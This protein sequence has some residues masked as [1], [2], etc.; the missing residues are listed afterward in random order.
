LRIGLNLLHA[1]PAIGGAWNYIASVL[2][3]L[4]RLDTRNQYIAYCNPASKAL[5]AG[6]GNIQVHGVDWVGV[7]QIARIAY[8]NTWLQYRSRR[9]RL[10]L[11]HW[12]ANVQS[13]VT[14]V[15]AAITVYDLRWIENLK[16]YDPLRMIYA[17]IMIPRSV[18]RA[19][20]IFPISA[21][22]GAGLEQR[23]GVDPE[24][25][26]V[27][28]YPL[29]PE[30]RRA[31]GPQIAELRRK[32][33]LPEK[34]WLYVAHSYPH[35]N[36]RTLFEAYARLKSEDASTWPLV[37]RGDDK[38]ESK[39]DDLAR[40]IG[41]ADSVLRLPPLDKED[42]PVLYSAA[43]ALV[44][45]SK[46]EGL[47]IPLLEALAC[48]CPAIASSIPT[49]L[50]FGGDNVVMCDPADAGAFTRAMAKF[51]SDRALLADYS[52]RG[53]LCAAN[54]SPARVFESLTAGYNYAIRRWR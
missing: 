42:M 17:R 7:N 34:L 35:K 9:D 13:L 52:N 28:N 25:I 48:G 5:V 10:D 26:F 15:P 31:T 27:I 44:F 22:T 24:K 4:K 6:A 19:S 3:V 14:A 11:M 53:V 37:L 54:F 40:E 23:L 30:W 43:T 45:P 39:L 51:Q 41:I 32:Y 33:A 29:G 20:A 2:E 50:E 46:Y 1:R 49:T 36:H 12:F 8:E 18:R 38:G 47:G 16:E 21:T